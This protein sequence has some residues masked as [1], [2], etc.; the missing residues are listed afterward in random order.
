MNHRRDKKN[1][2]TLSKFED[3]RGTRSDK[4]QWVIRELPWDFSANDGVTTHQFTNADSIYAVLNQY[5]YNEHILDL[6]EKL[7]ACFWKLARE[8]CTARQYEVLELYSQGM[9]QSEIAKKLGCIQSS[10]NKSL[11]GNTDY[12]KEKYGKSYGGVI[13]KLRKAISEDQEIQCLITEI[14]EYQ[15]DI[16]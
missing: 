6:R 14:K 15:T 13:K 9:T 2:R 7:R 5:E 16:L 12:S 1:M 10:I 4:Y 3:E 8:V 11:R